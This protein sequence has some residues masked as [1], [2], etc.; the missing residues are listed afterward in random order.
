MGR[1][2]ATGGERGGGRLKPT[3]KHGTKVDLLGVGVTLFYCLLGTLTWQ[4]GLHFPAPSAQ[5][6]SPCTATMA[7]GLGCSWGAP[8]ECSA[9]GSCCR[10][11]SLGDYVH[12][13][14]D[15][16]SD[17]QW[18]PELKN[19]CFTQL[20]FRQAWGAY[21]FVR[22]EPLQP[23]GVNYSA[24]VPRQA[25]CAAR[26][27]VWAGKM[28]SRTAANCCHNA[29]SHSRTIGARGRGYSW[30]KSVLPLDCMHE[31]QVGAI[32]PHP[33]SPLAH[34]RRHWCGPDPWLSCGLCSMRFCD[35]T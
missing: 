21:E 5:A 31:Q 34:L 27:L 29:I 3:L 13:F 1:G 9:R 2:G 6:A 18:V 32:L 22:A 24:I 15:A 30:Q 28:T 11:H 33:A 10:S 8:S 19:T 35:Q 20:R 26:L 23:D 12:D 14:T 16:Q 7:L 4:E 17:R 25:F